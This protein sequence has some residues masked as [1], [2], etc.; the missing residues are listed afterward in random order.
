MQIIPLAHLKKNW[1]KLIIQDGEQLSLKLAESGDDISTNEQGQVGI[2][3]PTGDIILSNVYCGGT[4]DFILQEWQDTLFN[5]QE[6][7]RLEAEEEERYFRKVC[8]GNLDTY[9]GIPAGFFG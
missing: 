6:I 2:E 7:E 9:Y 4:I 5:E 1:R 8:K 3:L